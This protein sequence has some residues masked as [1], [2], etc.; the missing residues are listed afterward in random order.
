M[1]YICSKSSMANN[2][3]EKEFKKNYGVSIVDTSYFDFNDSFNSEDI[4]VLDLVQFDSIDKTITFFNKIPKIVKVIALVDE[5]KLAHGAFMIKSGFKSYLS[6]RTNKIIIEQVLSTVSSGNIWLYP[7]LM[8]YIIK[9]ININNDDNKSSGALEK[10][11]AKEKEVANLVAEG[12]SNKEIAQSLD[13]QLV[14]IKKHIGNI[15]SK[16]S[17][18]D[19][20]A[21]AILINT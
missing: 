19:R 17:I 2:Y 5:P 8:N 13:V 12:M 9:H 6:K 14:T 4:I 16:L 18:K 11:S 10:L 21:L 20:V 3:W 1:I 7:E 15:F